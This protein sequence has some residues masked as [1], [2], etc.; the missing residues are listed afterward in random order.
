[1]VIEAQ[2][3]E[4][5]MVATQTFKYKS[6]WGLR[7]SSAK[8]FLH[9]FFKQSFPNERLYVLA[10]DSVGNFI[11]FFEAA[12]GTVNSASIHPR[13]IVQPLMVMNASRCIFV[14]NHPADFDRSFSEADISM[15]KRFKKILSGVSIELVDH[16]VVEEGDVIS[17][18]KTQ[19]KNGSDFSIVVPDFS[20]A[21]KSF[22]PNFGGG[23]NDITWS[24]KS[25]SQKGINAL[26]RKEIVSE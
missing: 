4:V 16:F 11:G 20:S 1:M 3:Y 15:T 23:I 26:Y 19:Q 13:Q 17:Y 14:H 21:Y 25:L 2:K 9:K 8:E 12:V 5:R 22:T 10:F 6:R 7:D 24:T 18:N